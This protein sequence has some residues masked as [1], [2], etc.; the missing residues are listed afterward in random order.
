MPH[1]ERPELDERPS[2]TPTAQRGGGFLLAVGAVVVAALI[3]AYVLVGTPGLHRPVA[4]APGQPTDVAQQPAPS[5]P[6][7][8]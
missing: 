8:R 2:P 6:A 1:L 7:T 4:S 5:T 3:G